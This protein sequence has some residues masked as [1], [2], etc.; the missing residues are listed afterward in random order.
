MKRRDKRRDQ[1]KF[2]RH[3]DYDTF[4]ESAKTQIERESPIIFPT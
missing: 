3:V 4:P 1:E 2:K